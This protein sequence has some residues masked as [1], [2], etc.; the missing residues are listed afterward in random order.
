VHK[1]SKEQIWY[2]YDC[3]VGTITHTRSVTTIARRILHFTAKVPW[4][5]DNTAVDWDLHGSPDIEMDWIWSPATLAATPK[6]PQGR[7]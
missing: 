4:V 5:V 3:K 7:G 6:E 1:K 2:T